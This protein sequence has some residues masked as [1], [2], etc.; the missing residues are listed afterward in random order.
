MHITSDQAADLTGRRWLALGWNWASWPE[1]QTKKKTRQRWGRLPSPQRPPKRP[2]GEAAA[3]VHHGATTAFAV[4]HR[5]LT[6]LPHPA[7]FSPP[8]PSTSLLCHPRGRCWRPFMNAYR[9]IF[10]T[11]GQLRDG[12]VWPTVAGSGRLH[13][14][15]RPRC[16]ILPRAVAPGCPPAVSSRWVAGS[17]P[18]RLVLI[19]VASRLPSAMLWEVFSFFFKKR[20]YLGHP[21]NRT[22]RSNFGEEKI[23]TSSAPNQPYI[24]ITTQFFEW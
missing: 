2:Q 17:G 18:M 3:L 9:V 11:P 20:I 4:L 23:S 19:S 13:S 24:Y 10:R 5:L 15:M 14:H 22:I 6:A 16:L 8:M 12:Q 21:C 7:S 1:R